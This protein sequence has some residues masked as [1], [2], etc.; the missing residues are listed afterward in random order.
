M[1]TKQ[2]TLLG[3]G[4]PDGEQQ[5]KGTQENCC[6]T[7]LTVLGFMM[8]GFISRLSLA[9]HSDSGFFLVVH[10]LLGQDRFQKGGF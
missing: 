6:A 3:G 7:W 1:M 4:P 2:E 9:N 10:T 5:D 8:M